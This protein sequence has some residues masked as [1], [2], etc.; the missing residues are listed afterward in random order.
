MYLDDL[1][2][3]DTDAE[4]CGRLQAEYCAAITSLG[5]PI[6]QRKLVLPCANGVECVGMEVHGR[7]HTVGVAPAKLS[8][9]VSATEALLRRR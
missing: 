4:R 5:L 3:L 6:K 2:I 9:L 8:S 1:N 7:D